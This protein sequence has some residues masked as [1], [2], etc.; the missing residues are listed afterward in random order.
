[1][2]ER[3]EDSAGVLSCSAAKLT[4]EQRMDGGWMSCTV[5]QRK[6]GI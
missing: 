1:M 4:H 6:T 5:L 3:A 2:W